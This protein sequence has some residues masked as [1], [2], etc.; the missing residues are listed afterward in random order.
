MG[1]AFVGGNSIFATPLFGREF[2]ILENLG[3]GTYLMDMK[4]ILAATAMVALAGCVGGELSKAQKVSPDGTD[5]DNALSSGYLRLAQAEQKEHDYRDADYFA[6]RA[7]TSANALIVLPPEVGDRDLPESE[8]IYVLGLRNELV[9]VL[10]GGARI[11]APQLAASA[12]IAYE[13]W[14][15]ELEENIQQDEI[16][17]CRDQLDGLIPAL[18]NAI[19]DE[20]AAA[21]APAPKP[22]RVRGKLFKILFP[23][24]GTK[25]DAEANAAVTEAAGHVANFKAPRVVVSGYTDTEGSAASNLTLSEKRARVVAAA[26]RIRG[27]AADLMKVEGYGEDFPDVRTADGVAEPKNRRVEVNVGGR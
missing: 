25:L 7:I 26:L 24:G 22:K 9:E 6:T 5:F 17:A 23:T 12:Q 21:P 20:V 3:K 15:Q 18:R 13:C 8:Q 27:I 14:I 19:T 4:I 1:L 2:E 11:R 16:A 10:D